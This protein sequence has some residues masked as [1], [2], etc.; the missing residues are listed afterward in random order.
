MNKA[1]W[2]WLSQRNFRIYLFQGFTVSWNNPDGKPV[3]RIIG[4]T[5]VQRS[6]LDLIAIREF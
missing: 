1:R 2:E 4:F 6:G 5:W 3:L